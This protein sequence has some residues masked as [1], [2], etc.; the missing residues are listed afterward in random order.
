MHQR[1]AAVLDE[2]VEEIASIQRA[3]RVEGR[4]ERPRW[5]MI[6]LRTPK[7]WTGPKDVDGLPTEGSWRSHQV[8][9]AE[10]R[11]NADHLALSSSRGC[12]A[13]GPP[14]CSTSTGTLVPELAALPP[15][16]YRRMS[17][18]PHANGGL[19]LKDLALPDFTDYAVAVALP[20]TTF[21]E[22]TRVLGGYLRDVIKMNPDR[23]RL[24]GPDETASNRLGA[25]LRGDRPGMGWPRRWR[26]T[27]TC[28]PTGA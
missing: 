23:F 5:P 3:A 6:V 14:S 25:G 13:T 20:G 22:A 2:V 7:G 15:K 16:S 8:P 10:V 27:I 17:A 4:A 24:F 11:T 19:L 21:A 26:P 9:L 28:R 18:N 12:A 1:M